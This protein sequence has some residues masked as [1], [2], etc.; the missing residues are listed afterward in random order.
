MYSKKAFTLVEMIV[1]VTISMLLMTSVW[2]LVSSVM[3]NVLKQQNIMSKNSRLTQTVSEFYNN[4]NNISVDSWYIFSSNSW[5]IFKID[6]NINKWG[7]GYF[8]QTTLTWEY[9]SLES[10]STQMN[11]LTW[12]SFIP[13]EEI[14]EDIFTDFSKTQQQSVSSWSINYRVD[15]VNHQVFED[16][17][18]IIWWE[19]F[20]HEIEIN[21]SWLL[22]RL[23]NP[24]AIVLA[25][26][27]FF[28]SDTLNHRIL[29]YKDWN[30]SLILDQ[31]DWLK[32]PTGLVYDEN[33]NIL[34][35][36]NSWKGEIL[37]LSSEIIT[38][39]P[40][41]NL[42]FEPIEDIDSISRIN[43]SF[44]EFSWNLDTLDLSDFS[45]NNINNW[46]WYIQQS[47]NT[48]EYY[49]TDY[50]ISNTEQAY[51]TINN[52]S[53]DEVYWLDN[54][55]PYKLETDCDSEW[56]NTWSIMRHSWNL[57][58]DFLNNTSYEITL[59]NI[60]PVFSSAE[61]YLLE[62]ELFE[63]TI[64]RYNDSFQ[65]FTQWDGIINN[66]ENLTFKTLISWLDYPTGLAINGNDLE[67][68]DFISRTQY[69]YNLD[70]LSDISSSNLEEFSSENLATIPYTQESDTL[71]ENPISEIN[72][73]Y[74]S[75]EKF[76][77]T[78]IEYYQYFNCYNPDEQVKKSF[79]L[80]KNID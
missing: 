43:I 54:Y 45:F 9:C 80:Q 51:W 58:Q 35:I 69:S 22:T 64:S 5:S 67:I 14:W 71:L 60:S 26:W 56:W 77:S 49:F 76:L 52:C 72:I 79:V 21:Q 30:I 3:Q 29:F 59:E 28:L 44:P 20:W 55:T 12:K 37:S 11:Y 13:Y 33:K 16:D 75:T 41:I 40:D 66:W 15:T 47:A 57:N 7:F 8:W 74:D 4:F 19:V 24:T 27:G 65:Y 48:V 23:N 46:D 63:D 42:S 70:D 39:N 36:S 78:Q 17:I 34:Y 6:Q 31:N 61:N 25:E 38:Q 53:S 32:E 1:W 18:L 2:I 10:E 73:N 62:I 50:R 68:N